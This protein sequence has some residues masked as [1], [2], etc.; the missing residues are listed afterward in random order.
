EKLDLL[1][2]AIE[3]YNI[4]GTKPIQDALDNIIGSAYQQEKIRS[5]ILKPSVG[6]K[7]VKVVLTLFCIIGAF[8]NITQLPENIKKLLPAPPETIQEAIDKIET[9]PNDKE[10]LNKKE[11]RK[12]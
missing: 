11:T 12:K 3:L 6:K 5:D 1:R 9:G 4:S 7:F 10:E 2:Q 8:N